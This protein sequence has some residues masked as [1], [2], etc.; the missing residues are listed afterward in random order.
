M[1]ADLHIDAN[2]ALTTLSTLI[3]HPIFNFILKIIY[4]IKDFNLPLI[5]FCTEILSNLSR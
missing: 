1:H 2:T 3:M 5:F 4:F